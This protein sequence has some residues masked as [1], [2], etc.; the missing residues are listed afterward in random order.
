MAPA[1]VVE[2]RETVRTP[3]TAGTQGAAS[4]ACTEPLISPM[5]ASGAS[6]SGTRVRVVGPVLGGAVAVTTST[7]MPWPS[8]AAS[9]LADSAVAR[10][11]AALSVVALAW[12]T[13]TVASWPPPGMTV[14]STLRVERSTMSPCADAAYCP[15]ARLCSSALAWAG[16]SH[17]AARTGATTSAK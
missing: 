7:G 8:S 15:A 9:R 17:A 3:F 2:A 6:G 5:S 14:G 12:P 10:W 11:A 16:A 13:L 1:S 4:V